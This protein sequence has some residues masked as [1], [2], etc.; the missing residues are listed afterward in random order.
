MTTVTGELSSRPG[1]AFRVE[2]FASAECDQYGFGEGE[3]PLGSVDVVTDAT[4]VAAFTATVE[5][6]PGAFVSATATDPEGNTSEF[7][8]CVRVALSWDPPDP[9]SGSNPPP[10]NLSVAPSDEG[11]EPAI[12]AA[13][14]GS[15][16]VGYRVY[17]AKVPGQ[18]PSPGTLISSVPPTQTSAT[19]PAGPGGSFFVVTAVY[20]TGESGPSNEAEGGQPPAIDSFRVKGRKIV[21][22]GSGFTDGVLVIVDGLPFVTP[23]KVKRRN[24]RVVQTGQLVT[25]QTLA[26]YLASRRP[27]EDGTVRVLVGIRNATGGVA[28]VEHRFEP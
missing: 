18:P 15:T 2:L 5:A 21:A 25:G 24:T 13:P 27:D 19:V 12:A 26:E 16:L 7:S 14:R 6:A 20:D 11:R 1:T 22:D 3:I 28:T 4:G 17:G 8:S 9:Q 10:R 23:A